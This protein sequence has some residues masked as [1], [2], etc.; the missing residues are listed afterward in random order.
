MW[1]MALA[2]GE[3][4]AL[5]DYALLAALLTLVGLILLQT[6]APRGDDRTHV[7]T[8]VPAGGNA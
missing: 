1:T 3:N 8:I 2:H 5:L 7:P 6:H 4:D